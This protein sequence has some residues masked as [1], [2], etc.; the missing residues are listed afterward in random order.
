MKFDFEDNFSAES[1]GQDAPSSQERG[2]THSPGGK[3]S[4]ARMKPAWKQNSKI[5]PIKSE[6]L[7][8]IIEDIEEEGSS[9]S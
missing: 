8:N 9:E 4:G 6:D 2:K 3:D 5:A 1:E 7:S